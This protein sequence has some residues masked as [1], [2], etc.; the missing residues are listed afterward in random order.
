LTSIRELSLNPANHAQQVSIGRFTTFAAVATFLVTFV[1]PAVD[2]QSARVSLEPGYTQT[3]GAIRDNQKASIQIRFTRVR[4][5]NHAGKTRQFDVRMFYDPRTKLFLW[6]YFEM[7]QDYS[8]EWAAK[9]FT[10]F[11]GVYLTFNKLRIFN[12]TGFG[13]DLTILE[14]SERHESIDQVQNTVVHFF[15]KEPIPSSKWEF[16]HVDYLKK[17]PRDFF[18]QCFSAFNTPPTVEDVQHQ[19]NQWKV[20]VRVK[21]NGNAAEIT[22]DDSYNLIFTKFIANPTADSAGGC[23]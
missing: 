15:E 7:Y 23:N 4:V 16:K 10:P 11:A 5:L 13:Y 1:C 20:T 14:S 9:Q 22:L 2:A 12:N 6:G 18:K 3:I 8:S 17:V 21:Q 19:G